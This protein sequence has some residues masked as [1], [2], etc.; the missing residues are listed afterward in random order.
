MITNP[1]YKFRCLAALLSLWCVGDTAQWETDAVL[2]LQ[3]GRHLQGAPVRI[4]FPR[5]EP[6]RAGK[7]VDTQSISLYLSSLHKFIV[8]LSLYGVTDLSQLWSK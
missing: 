4:Q 1:H 8:T 5:G 7:Q 2:K 6:F 3:S